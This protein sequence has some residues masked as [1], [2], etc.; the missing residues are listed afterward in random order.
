MLEFLTQLMPNVIDKWPAFV[1]ACIESLQM[2]SIAGAVSF[3]FGL[4]FGVILVVTNK[5]G[6]LENRLVWTVLDKLVNVFRAIPFVIL[7][8][9]LMDVTRL[10][11]G[12][13]IGVRGVIFP[14]I[15]GTVPFFSRQI[16]SALAEVDYGLIEAS[17]ED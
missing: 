4:I 17:E 3:V 13:T 5:N 10:V 14:L 7:I 16:E 8:A 1:E 9:L 12:T 11:S 6:I 2:I 15:I